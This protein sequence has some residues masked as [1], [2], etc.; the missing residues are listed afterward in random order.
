MSKDGE[1][2]N[3]VT[4]GIPEKTRDRAKEDYEETYEQIL[5]AGMK[6]LDGEPVGEF[7]PE[8]ISFEQVATANQVREIN[9]QLEAIA[10]SASMASEPTFDDDAVAQLMNRIDD[11]QSQ[12]PKDVAQEVGQ[13]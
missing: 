13:R 10:N 11:L 5:K 7:D 3:W 12:L 8:E 9:E 2:T 6:A 1:S 4:I